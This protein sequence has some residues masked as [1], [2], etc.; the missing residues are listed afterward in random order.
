M[1]AI[2]VFAHQVVARGTFSTLPKQLFLD[3]RIEDVF[4]NTTRDS[5]LLEPWASDYV[6]SIRQKRYGDAIWARYHMYGDM[7]NGLVGWANI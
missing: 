3:L 4:D 1:L 5:E 6:E 7:E 2:F